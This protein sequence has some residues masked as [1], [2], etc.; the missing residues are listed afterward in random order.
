MLVLL[1]P[2]AEPQHHAAIGDV[3]GGDRLL[4][5]HG[6]IA[7][8]VAA[9]QRAEAHPVGGLGE[10]REGGPRLVDGSVVGAH[11]GHEVISEPQSVPTGLLRPHAAALNLVPPVS[12]A[13][14]EA[15]AHEG[16]PTV[17]ILPDAPGRGAAAREC[18]WPA[19][20]GWPGRSNPSR[21]DAARRRPHRPGRPSSAR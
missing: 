9:H 13:D 18:R 1:P 14:P 10:R 4:E 8:G 5:Q 7:V 12:V 21:T 20:A 15:K 19:P 6:R 17:E 11:A 3:V 16:Q 2:G